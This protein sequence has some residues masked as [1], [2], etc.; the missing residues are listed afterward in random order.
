[1]SGG[2]NKGIGTFPVPLVTRNPKMTGVIRHRI[3]G[4]QLVLQAEWAC[5]VKHLYDTHGN[6]LPSDPYYEDTTLEQYRLIADSLPAEKQK[7]VENAWLTGEQRYRV[8]FW[9]KL[10]ILQVE[11]ESSVGNPLTW[12]N[13]GVRRWRDARPSDV[14]RG[15]A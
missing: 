6:W 2:G 8:S 15:L 7:M 9:K 10:L 14:I 3:H 11:Y 1:M 12:R 4:D 5:E 13:E